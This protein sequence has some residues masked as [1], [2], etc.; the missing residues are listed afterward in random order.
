MC[1][2][3]CVNS[4]AVIV[5]RNSDVSL[6]VC[7]NSDAVIVCRNSDVSLCVCEQ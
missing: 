1:H 3:V 2:C 6:C 4:D 7:V 5:C